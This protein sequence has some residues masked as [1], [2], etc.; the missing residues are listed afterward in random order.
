MLA[1]AVRVAAQAC[2]IA[3]ALWK[4]GEILVSRHK[5]T[6]RRLARLRRP[7]TV[8]LSSAVALAGCVGFAVA[9][10]YDLIPGPLTLSPVTV[11][12]FASPRGIVSSS[13]IVASV[14][15]DQPLDS[16]ALTSLADTFAAAPGVGSDYSLIVTSSDGETLLNRNGD[17]QR[18]PAS[19]MKTLTALAASLALDTASTL[20]TEVRLIQSESGATITLTGH[21]DMLLGAGDSDPSHINGRAGLG[22]LAADTAAALEQRGI[23]SVNLI[24]DDSLFGSQRNVPNIEQNNGDHVYATAVS[25]MAVDG[26][27]TWD[28]MQRP[29]NP[30]EV[31]V[32]PPLSSTT[33]ADAA[34]IFAAKLAEHGIAV[35]GGPTEGDTP[36]DTSPIAAVHSATIGEIMAF[37]L[38]NSDNTQAELLGRLT[39]LK[40]GNDNSPAGATAAVASQLEQAGV[41]TD[42]LVM[43]DCSGLAPGSQLTVRTLSGVQ[44]AMIHGGN[45]TAAAAEGL[46]VTGLNGTVSVRRHFS[47]E[48]YGLVRAKT[49]SL[50]GVRSLSGNCSRTS[51]GVLIFSII[52]NHSSDAAAANTAIDAFVSGLVQL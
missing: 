33:A 46:A 42:G 3:W 32:Y 16:A 15:Q 25:S 8:V 47:E 12:S 6:G 50:S 31:H 14:E 27:R 38:R 21:G 44:H 34:H 10:I 9:D 51:G 5:S 40:T 30:D 19:T 22:T 7:L 11:R 49:G 36:A 29:S 26:G 20:D 13:P 35:N 24:Y 28:T 17:A 37:M 41:N 39:A 45:A 23:A 1:Y 43:G 4:K 52:V 2:G 18:E 48:S